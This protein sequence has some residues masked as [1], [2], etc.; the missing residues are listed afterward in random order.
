MP[1]ES[2]GYHRL[3]DVKHMAIVTY[4]FRRIPLSPHRLFFPI[5]SKGSFIC[6]FPQTERHIPYTAFDRPVAM[7]AQTN[8]PNLYRGAMSSI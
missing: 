4:F 3:L 8:D 6:T 7:Q 5:N 2:R 1:L